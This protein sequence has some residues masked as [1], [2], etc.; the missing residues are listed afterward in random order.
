MAYIDLTSFVYFNPNA[1]RR[2]QD[3]IKQI[4]YR[5][6]ENLNSSAEFNKFGGKFKYSKVQKI[7][8]DADHF[9]LDLFAEDVADAIEEF[10]L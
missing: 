5:T 1:T 7:I 4:I 10:L 9:F 8:D 3:D 2:T 6:L